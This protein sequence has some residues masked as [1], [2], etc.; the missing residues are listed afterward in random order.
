M[1]AHCKASDRHTKADSRKEIQI[2]SNF[3]SSS[4]S[5]TLEVFS[6]AGAWKANATRTM[7]RNPIATNGQHLA[8]DL[9]G[10]KIA[11]YAG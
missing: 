1:P 2:G 7:A 8:I 3:Q 6:G 10:Y 9:I 5:D 11:T 4:L